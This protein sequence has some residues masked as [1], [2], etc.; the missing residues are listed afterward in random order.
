MSI[1]TEIERLGGR[2]LPVIL[3]SPGDDQSYLY[4]RLRALTWF[5]NG[6]IFNQVQAAAGR[7]L[8][9][10]VEAGKSD[11]PLV[12]NCQDVNNIDEYAL[13]TLV[14]SIGKGSRTVLFTQMRKSFLQDLETMTAR[15]P[16]RQI[17]LLGETVAAEFGEERYDG[18]SVIE[19]MQASQLLERAHVKRLITDSYVRFADGKLHRLS[20]TPI[21]A[22]GAFNAQL[23]ASDPVAFAWVCLLLAERVNSIIQKYRPVNPS[24]LAATLR[25][26]LF[27]AAVSEL[28]EPKTPI[29]VVDHLGPRQ[30]ILER[31]LGSAEG[32]VG[33]YIYF[34]DF[35]LLGSELKLARMYAQHRGIRMRHAVAIGQLLSTPD[36]TANLDISINTLLEL[37]SCAVGAQYAIC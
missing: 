34:G 1:Q 20:S 22:S 14:A 36:Y 4:T 13:E 19:V 32:N 27:A 25:S 29:S 3:P 15:L 17:H 9:S 33:E 35:I 21:L 5:G 31:E 11:S 37:Q 23:I 16:H 24:I 6:L 30:S 18:D 7:L 28:L 12:V 2:E 8:G 26:S 10:I